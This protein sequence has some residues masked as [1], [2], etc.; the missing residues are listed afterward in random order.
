MNLDELLKSIRDEG[1][2]ESSLT[3]KPRSF[4]SSDEKLVE[5]TIDP[6]VLAALGIDFTGDLTY[7][8]YVT[9]LKE[10]MAA[11]RMKGGGDSGAADAVFKEFKRV[12][13]KDK[14]QKFKVKKTK[15]KASSIKSKPSPASR[16][17][18]TSK[19]LPGGGQKMLPSADDT[20]ADTKRGSRRKGDPLLKEVTIIKKTTIKIVDILKRQSKLNKDQIRRRRIAI[21]KAKK[22]NAEDELEG[23]SGV[24]GMVEKVTKPLTNIFDAIKRFLLFTLLGS[25]LGAIMKFIQNPRMIF[26]PI[27]D[28]VDG[29]IDFFNKVLNFINDKLIGS[30]NF[31]ISQI[32]NGLNFFVDRINSVLSFIPGSPQIEKIELP[33]IPDIPELEGPDLTGEKAEAKKAQEAASTPQ[34]GKDGK[35]GKDA[36]VPTPQGSKDAPAP[37]PTDIA[38][39][40]KPPV[41]NLPPQKEK[42]PSDGG[43]V[44]AL[45]GGGLVGTKAQRE[46]VKRD[47]KLHK[48]LLALQKDRTLD[49]SS[50]L[51]TQG[52]KVDNK[53]GVRVS[54]LGKDTQLTAL[55]PNEFVLTPKA[56]EGLGIDTL[57]AV[58][59]AYGGTNTPE[60]TKLSDISLMSGGGIVAGAKRV[61]GKGR[62]VGDQCANTTRAALSAAGHPAA[63]KRT[64][65]GDLDTPKGTGYNAP[66]FAASFGGTDMGKVI[67][68][69]SQI[70]AGDIVLWRADR[71]KGGN[72]NKGA[73]THV[74]IAADDGLKHQYDHNTSRGFHYRPHWHSSAGTSWFAGIRLGQSGGLVPPEISDSSGGT[75]YGAPQPGDGRDSISS[76]ASFK[77][78]LNS[79]PA[80]MGDYQVASKKPPGAPVKKTPTVLPLPM[81][82]NQSGKPVGGT[83]SGGGTP[84][85]SFSSLNPGEMG[86]RSAVKSIL[87]VMG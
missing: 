9:I 24:M 76:A 27:Q 68:N 61:L 67:T 57:L 47:K 30:I 50:K 1:K 77:E 20:D 46:E 45:R 86:R 14:G 7:G 54:G 26:K 8:E 63:S 25:I 62:G 12:Q 5:E 13:R 65:V 32:Q 21:G 60:K 40:V 78:A 39:K 28:V 79:S 44:Q 4:E 73:I 74:G 48:Q 64:Q 70:K 41:V 23:S 49:V 17:V 83:H 10:K 6:T 22:A 72:I 2:K 59:K 51:A 82:N 71:D 33:K 58:N 35:D 52:G 38:P 75:G 69:K 19:F 55:T 11:Q 37:K 15:I 43:M 29:V 84:P 66:S 56:A 42:S 34:D 31:V 81:G 18:S 53:T 80:V 16:K 36:S 87:G 85:V 3:V